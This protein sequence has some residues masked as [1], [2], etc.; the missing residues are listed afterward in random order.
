MRTSLLKASYASR[1]R[2]PRTAVENVV[3]ESRILLVSTAS[4]LEALDPGIFAGRIGVAETFGWHR[5]ES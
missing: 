3:R 2:V 5:V 4:W 1:V